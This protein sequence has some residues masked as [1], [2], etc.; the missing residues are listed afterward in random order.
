MKLESKNTRK[1]KK[2]RIERKKE[3]CKNT[4]EGVRKP[5]ENPTA[6]AFG[7]TNCHILL[8]LS[9]AKNQKKKKIKSFSFILSSISRQ[10]KSK[11]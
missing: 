9:R 5:K 6:K 1:R 10:T 2:L 3:K 4:T 8:F 7:L 11:L